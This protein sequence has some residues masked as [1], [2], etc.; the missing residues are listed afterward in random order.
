MPQ[1]ESFWNPY[2]LIPAKETIERSS[3]QTHERFC[4]NCGTI[5]CTIENLTPLFIGMRS[6]G[7]YH[8]PLLRNGRRVIPGSS[9]KG[10]LRALVEIVGGGCFVVH[11]DRNTPKI[12]KSPIPNE[13]KACDNARR[14]CIACR[15][16]GA[17]ERTSPARVHQGKVGIGD[18][19]IRS[20]DIRTSS[21]SVLLANSGV[22]HEPF[23]RS[24]QTGRLDGKGRKL[25]FHQPGRKESTSAIPQNLLDRK[26]DID[27][28][29]PGHRFDFQVQFSNLSGTEFSLL[30]YSLFLEDNVSVAIQEGDIRLTGPMRHKIGNAKPLGMGSCHIRPRKLTLHSP[31]E[32]RFSNMKKPEDRIFE[33][34]DLEREI[35][36]RIKPHLE[37]ESPTMTALRKMMVW[38]ESDPRTF[39]YPDYNWF[40]TEKGKQAPLKNI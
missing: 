22:R 34:G 8:P 7:E 32:V 24:P 9:L 12:P 17:M 31:P 39:R 38:D 13:M 16:F 29:L 37:D 23:Y 1:G 6:S 33:E 26:W 40:Q 25:Y 18:A 2:R 3:P 20:T 21:F 10:M 35:R 28:L 19:L 30:L 36:E 27:A 5:T 14:L 11:N 4:G 15:M